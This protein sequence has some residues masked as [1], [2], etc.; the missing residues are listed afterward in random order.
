MK[1]NALLA[2]AV[3]AVLNAPGAH[4]ISSFDLIA[5]GALSGSRA[6]AYA[7]LSGLTGTLENGLPANL[8][9]GIG[10]G[11]AYAGGSTYLALP[12]RG[13][14]AT[15]YNPAVDDTVSYISRFQT[16]DMTL[17]ATPSGVLPYTLTPVLTGTTLLSSPTPLTYGSGTGLGNRIDGTPLGAGAPAQN[18][19]NTYYFTG[20]S[21]NFN[22]SLP[23]TNPTNARLDP[24]GIRVANDGKSVFVS[25]EYGPYVYQFDRT[26]GR[27]INTFTLPSNLAVTNLSPLG[28]EEING[29]TVGRVANKGMEGLAITPDGKTLVGIMQAPLEQDTKKN[30]R[31]VTIDIAS[32]ATHEYAYKLSTGSGVSEIVALNDHEFLVDE[33]DGKGLGDGSTAAVKQIFKIDLAGA[34]DVSSLSGDLSSKAVAKTLFLDVVNALGAKG[35]TAD[36]VPS[37]LEGLA[38]GQ[39]ITDNGQLFHTLWVANDNDFVSAVAGPNN[40][41]VFAIKASDLPSF[42]AQNLSAV[43][44]PGAVWLMGS[45]LVGI[46]G[47]RRRAG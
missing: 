43:P 34:Q 14:N 2:A 11:F 28:T 29:N 1:H 42:S 10:S 36:Q 4:A 38:F 32:G 26:T 13:P 47:R 3:A 19:A 25:D 7:D 17:T 15:P 30:V 37:K 18:T 16:V 20:R 44:L 9:G 24:E 40:F 21:D 41:Y 35:I 31:I 8:L 12:D 46:A 45:A 23:S 5:V 6:G 22:P 33:R 27:R 39:D